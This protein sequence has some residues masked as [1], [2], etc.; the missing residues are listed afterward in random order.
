[1][2]ELKLISN[3]THH[4]THRKAVKV[5]IYKNQHSKNN[6]RYL[7][8]H[9]GFD[10]SLSPISKRSRSTRL[11]H[12]GNHRAKH[13]QEK[14]Y[15]HVPGVGYLL[16]HTILEHSIQ[17]FREAPLTNKKAPYQDANKQR[18]ISFFGNKSQDDGYHRRNQSPKCSMKIRYSFCNLLLHNC[19]LLIYRNYKKI[20]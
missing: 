11:V 4:A 5:V 17:K 20:V 14:E 16:D 10:M 19:L 12:Q 6:R 13:H 1:M 3:R 7:R 2:T 18:R 8:T 9:F 15:S